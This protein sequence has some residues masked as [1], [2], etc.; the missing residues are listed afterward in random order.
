MKKK[1]Q[2]GARAKFASPMPEGPNL[3]TEL[4]LDL[5]ALLREI[6]HM[7]FRET[8]LRRKSVE[9]TLAIFLQSRLGT[10][11]RVGE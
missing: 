8:D 11:T 4:K 10:N 7:W 6:S 1:V 9:L 3:P 2:P 5:T